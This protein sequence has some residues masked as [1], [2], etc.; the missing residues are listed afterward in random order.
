VDELTRHRSTGLCDLCNKRERGSFLSLISGTKFVV[1]DP[2]NPDGN[3]DTRVD[4]FVTWLLKRHV[5]VAELAVAD[6]FA[7]SAVERSSYLKRQGTHLRRV[8][9]GKSMKTHGYDIAVR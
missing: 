9:V 2:L 4:Q 7:K 6:L 1:R 8:V 5:A 3:E